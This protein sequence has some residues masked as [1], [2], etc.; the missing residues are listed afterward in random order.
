[1]K[2]LKYLMLGA[3]ILGSSAQSV[4]QD[5]KATLMVCR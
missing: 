1:M 2:T 3:L 5:D 4:A